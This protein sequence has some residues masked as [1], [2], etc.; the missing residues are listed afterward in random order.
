MVQLIES[1]GGEELL[2]FA[3]DYPHW[4]TDDP[5]YIA[6]RLPEKWHQKIFHDNAARFFGWKAAELAIAGHGHKNEAALTED[7]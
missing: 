3:S 5:T 7:T 4:D 2:C 1:F 6:G